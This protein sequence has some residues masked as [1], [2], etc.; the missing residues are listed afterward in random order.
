[1]SD[2]INKWPVERLGS[3]L[4]EIQPGFASGK[5]NSTGDGVPHFRPM[6]VSR[7]GQIDRAVLKY[8]DPSTGRPDLRLR[9]G[10][11]LFNNTNSPELVGKTAR[12][13]GAD[14]PAFSNH[15][16]RLR[17]DQTRLDPTFLALRLHQAWRDGWF[18]E[19]FNNHVS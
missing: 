11:V 16:T 9:R 13:D 19:N 7:D 8:V 10:D 14:N 3:L 17:A 2:S 4:S 1:V 6:N 15:M 18:L 12:F 5:H